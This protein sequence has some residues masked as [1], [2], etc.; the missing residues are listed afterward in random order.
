MITR[1][2]DQSIYPNVTRAQLLGTAAGGSMSKKLAIACVY[3]LALLLSS[4]RAQA[5]TTSNSSS[6]CTLATQTVGQTATTNCTTLG[7]NVC[8][9]SNSCNNQTPCTCTLT[10]AC[11]DGSGRV[12]ADPHLRTFD[13]LFYDFQATGE[14]IV[15]DSASIVLQ[16]RQR[17]W[18]DCAAVNSSAA[19][20]V[21]TNRIAVYAQETP[22]LRVNGNPT[23]IPCLPQSTATSAGI[24]STGA[25]SSTNCSGT[26]ALVDSSQIVFTTSNGVLTY[27]LKGSNGEQLANI[28]VR[29][30][31]YLDVSVSP[32]SGG[33][34]GLL[35]NSD[36]DA[37]NDLTTRDGR[38][39]PQ[40]ITST[41]LYKD[42][43]ESWRITQ[44]ESLF[45]Y[46]AG[47]DTGTFTD[48]AFPSAPC[49]PP[50]ED[51]R[52]AAESACQA[53]GI[54]NRNLLTACAFDVANTGD[55]R[56]AASF[57]D[58]SEPKA[59]LTVLANGVDASSSTTANIDDLRGVKGCACRS[60]GST[61]RGSGWLFFLVPAMLLRCRRRMA[62]L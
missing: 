35:G 17:P 31:G 13:G 59:I 43:G 42:F 3:A 6:S 12:V 57:L 50:A 24:L 36:G 19:A 41:Q 21:G 18:G 34:A 26:M 2:G 23:D 40:P 22:P 60:A 16:V 5:F 61:T 14:F 62:S 52:L 44:G 8:N 58:I 20:M 39:I 28:T 25:G 11:C 32:G 55:T 49:P 47:E 7:L 37:T 45:D 9:S 38:V 4:L 54:T 48:R 53:A 1:T 33:T 56:F 51:K 27:S 15:V 29:P 30:A 10:Y 46:R